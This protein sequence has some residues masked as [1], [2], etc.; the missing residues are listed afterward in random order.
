MR[1][2]SMLN[3]C[4]YVCCFITIHNFLFIECLFGQKWRRNY[5]KWKKRE[6]KINKS[7]SS[8]LLWK[9]YV[10]TIFI[11]SFIRTFISKP[12]SLLRR[13]KLIYL[14][15]KIRNA[16]YYHHHFYITYV[17]EENSYFSHL[18]SRSRS[19]IRHRYTNLLD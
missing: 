8:V 5:N 12:A 13:I 3:V 11:H 10:N 7:K 14:S 15:I 19:I 9:K 4:F 2:K 17:D 18:E 1:E 6:K 16:K